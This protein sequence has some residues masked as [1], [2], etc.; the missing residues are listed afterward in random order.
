MAFAH[1]IASVELDGRPWH[2]FDEC[3]VFL[4]QKRETYTISVTY[5]NPETPHLVAT[6]AKVTETTW[7]DGVFGFSCDWN[8]WSEGAPE[9][10]RYHAAVKLEGRKL[11][12]IQNA[13]T[14][15]TIPLFRSIAFHELSGEDSIIHMVPRDSNDTPVKPLNPNGGVVVRFLPDAI[16]LSIQ[17]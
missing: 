12:E 7:T 14:V 3:F 8:E 15:R 13:E 9:T 17:E 11:L 5:G 4:P 2:Y 10:F 16:R 6:F 1:A